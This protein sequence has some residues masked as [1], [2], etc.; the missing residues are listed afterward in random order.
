M[1]ALQKVWSMV[2]I[3]FSSREK[4]CLSATHASTGFPRLGIPIAAAATLYLAPYSQVIRCSLVVM[5]GP[6]CKAAQQRSCLIPYTAS[7]LLF[8]ATPSYI[9]VTT[10]TVGC[11]RQLGRKSN[12]TK[13]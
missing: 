5:A 10:T 4:H 8:E 9:P 12:G 1:V 11:H 7:F 2:P 3:G 13:G 6:T